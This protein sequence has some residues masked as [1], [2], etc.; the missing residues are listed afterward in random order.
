MVV[1]GGVFGSRLGPDMQVYM[2]LFLVVIFIVVHLAAKPFDE[3]TP[4]HQI[5][6]WLELGALLICWGTL[7]SGMLFWLGSTAGRLE[8]GFLTL[9]SFTIIFGNV[10]FTFWLVF[11]F[12]CAVTRESKKDGEQSEETL[13]KLIRIR[14]GEQRGVKV[15]SQRSQNRLMDKIAK[16][17][18]WSSIS[19]LKLGQLMEMEKPRRSG[20]TIKR[21]DTK[22]IASD[23]L[24]RSTST[25]NAHKKKTKQRKSSASNRLQHR[26]K[27]R[28]LAGMST[29]DTKPKEVVGIGTAQCNVIKDLEETAGNHLVAEM[30]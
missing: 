27:R 5:L 12:V 15:S 24:K 2:A 22:K 13:R 10:L 29:G 18:K 4:S 14:S 28:S 21:G 25:S 9:V 17:N 3:L 7:Y 6:H 16:S 19:K 30:E 8:P 11:V 23:V 1:V 26:L 20:R